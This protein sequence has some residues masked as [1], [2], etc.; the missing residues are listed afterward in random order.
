MLR[1]TLVLFAGGFT[2]ILLRRRLFIHHWMGMVL[3]TVGRLAWGGITAWTDAGDAEWPCMI[4]GLNRGC[5]AAVLQC[6][7][8]MA[9]CI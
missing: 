2:M 1:G 7:F 3:I 5:M 6:M 9:K 8:M 4:E